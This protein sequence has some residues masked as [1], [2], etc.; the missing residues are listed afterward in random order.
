METKYLVHHGI[1]GQKWGKRNGP[2]YPLDYNDHSA[3]EKKGDYRSP[4]NKKNKP[5]SKT[6]TDGTLKGESRDEIA[7]KVKN[8]NQENTGYDAK[9]AKKD[10]NKV[11]KAK[12][13]TVRDTVFPETEV[14]ASNGKA[15][16]LANTKTVKQ[17]YE[18]NKDELRSLRKQAEKAQKDWK[19]VYEREMSKHD[20]EK[21]PDYEWEDISWQAELTASKEVSPKPIANYSN[22]CK[23]LAKEAFGELASTPISKANAFGNY[24]TVEKEI[25]NALEYIG[26]FRTKSMFYKD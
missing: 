1:A 5:L 19:K 23:E 2:P 12:Y 4:G 15:R 20:N 8:K 26:D 21:H 17:I 14:R 25:Q 10:F 11:K 24:G 22:R 18:N 13:V 6:I 3:A 16:A 9:Q 7:K